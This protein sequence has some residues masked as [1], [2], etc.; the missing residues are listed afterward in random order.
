MKNL[1]IMGLA[2]LLLF[3]LAAGL[4]LYL[5]QS[6]TATE[7]T[8]ENDDK[9]KAGKEK[10]KPEGVEKEKPGKEKSDSHDTVSARER[11]LALEKQKS[12]VEL[13]LAD[14]R[15]ER[16]ALDKLNKKWAEEN[17][18]ALAADDAEQRIADQTKNPAKK[19]QPGPDAAEQKN[20]DKLAAF[21]DSMQPDLAAK[22]IQ[23]MSNSGAMDT[24]VLIIAKM[25]DAKA[26]KVLEAMT[27][28]SLATQII[29]KIQTMRKAPPAVPPNT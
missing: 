10:E 3:S 7:T 18:A 21:F 14:M 24:A 17:K 9:K 8:K 16:E 19:P 25:K 26:A 13:V 6:K 1:V 15:S 5:Q 27:D 22:Q 2:S 4:S 29:R 23:E 12:R 28:V 11:E 20:I